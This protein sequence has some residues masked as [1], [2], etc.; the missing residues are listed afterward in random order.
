[1]SLSH[2]DLARMIDHTLL[3]PEAHPEQIDRLC[4]EAIEHGFFGICVHPV[5]VR[6]V[7]DRLARAS[8]GL[9]PA[10]GPAI[11][12]VAGFPLGCNRSEVKADEARR[13]I[14]DGAREID[15]VIHVG[16]LVSGDAR[17]V[18]NEIEALAHVVHRAPNGVLKVILETT[19]LTAD[20]IILGCR[21]CAEGEA[22]FVK[23]STGLHP[24]GGAT[25][26]HVRLLRRHAAPIRV[27]AAGGIRTADAALAMIEAGADRLGTS[28]GV[29]IVTGFRQRTA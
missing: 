18:R 21:C 29:A 17:S 15:M 16:S 7:A 22:D 3:I 27:K 2:E 14:D 23:T 19:A 1:M 8:S 20:Q 26:E 9:T 11:V 5:F 12:S 10:D 28:A 24:D 25:V 6:R 4:E 13:A